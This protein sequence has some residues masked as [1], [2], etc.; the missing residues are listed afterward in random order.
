MYP[1]SDC[2]AENGCPSAGAAAYQ[3]SPPVSLAKSQSDPSPPCTGDGRP[4]AWKLV[5]VTARDQPVQL[6]PAAVWYVS[7]TWPSV[8]TAK[9]ASWSLARCSAAGSWYAPPCETLV[10]YPGQRPSPAPVASTT[11]C[12]EVRT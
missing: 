6:P 9:T 5:V 10:V 7:H 2:H 12:V 11:S 4:D 3:V 1:P 8:P